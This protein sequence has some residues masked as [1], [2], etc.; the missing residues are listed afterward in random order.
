MSDVI[1]MGEM[2][3]DFVPME[4]GVPLR[5]NKGF[6]REPGGAPANVAVGVARLG[7]KAKF[8]GKLGRDSFG[9][10]LI[11]ILKKN[12][13]NIEDVVQTKEAKTALAFVTLDEKGERDFIFYRE[14]SA[15]MLYKSEELPGEKVF[16]KSK[17]FH[18]GSISLINS[19]VRET[20]LKCIEIAQKNYNIISF[21]PNLRPPLWPD[22]KTARKRIIAGLGKADLLKVSREELEFI[23]KEKELKKAC[24]RLDNYNI[25]LVLVSLGEKGCYIYKKGV[26]ANVPGYSVEVEDTTGAGDGFIAAVL[27]QLSSRDID[28][29]KKLSLKEVKDIVDF[30]N[31]VGALTTTDKGA[32]KSLPELKS[33]NNFLEM[34]KKRD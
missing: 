14:P 30:A 8:L 25:D 2:L 27:Y 9:D 17:I 6:Y 28:N 26:D 16:Q 23:T 4:K 32:I 10:F 5:Q 13:V 22:L 12:N 21:D 1:T 34:S 11:E 18:Y 20:T 3:I 15:D 29:L 7:G 33:V 19:P 31:A 24:I